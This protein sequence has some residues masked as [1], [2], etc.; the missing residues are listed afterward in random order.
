MSW[1][2]Y[3]KTKKVKAATDF[4]VE[5]QKSRKPLYSIVVGDF[6][7]RVPKNYNGYILRASGDK[8]KLSKKNL[9]Y[10]IFVDDPLKKY[11]NS[12]KTFYRKYIKKPVIGFC[13]QANPLRFQTFVDVLRVST[14]N[15][16]CYLGLKNF[17]PQKVMSTTY[18]RYKILNHLQNSKTVTTNFILRQEHRAGVI[19]D[20]DT[21]ITTQQFYENIRDSD[22]T[23]CMRGAGNFSVRFYETLAMGRIPVFV[24]TDCILPL[25]NKIN[26]KEHVVWVEYNER[27]QIT[28]KILEFHAQLDQ[29]KLNELFEKNRE[30]WENRLTLIPY[31]KTLFNENI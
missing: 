6:N 4:V 9:A 29:Y 20:K 5:V 19:K 22:Y 21:H 27:H 28:E 8:S 24:N 31:F 15:V 12:K 13:G 25:E 16:M 3:Y 10:P 18:F 17:E 2:Y 7:S 11:F 23:V 14:K 1:N 26:W 30:L